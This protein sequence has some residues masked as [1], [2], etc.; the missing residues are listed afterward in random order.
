MKK[1]YLF[2]VLLLFLVSCEKELDFHYHDVAPQLVIEGKISNAGSMVKLTRTCPMDE[3]MNH[4]PIVDAEIV[5]TDLTSEESSFLSVSDDGFFYDDSPG[6]IG[7]EYQI[8]V[9]YEGKSFQS[10]SLMRPPVRILDLEFQWIKMP[11]DYVAVLQISFLDLETTDDCYWIRLYRNGEPYMW[12]LSDDRSAVN[13]VINEVTM[14]SRKDIDEEDEKSVLKDGDEVKV[15]IAPIDR[16]MYDYLIAIQSDS[17]GPSM[18]SGDYCL[19][20]FIASTEAEAS[21]V[22]C[23]DLMEEFN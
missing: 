6:A 14:T 13:G 2:L 12:L 3:P 17:N 9:H 23:P 16:R 10:K 19:G 20:Y 1:L 5:I 21:I 18:F 11:Y 4:T 22:F 15:I 8:E 7:H